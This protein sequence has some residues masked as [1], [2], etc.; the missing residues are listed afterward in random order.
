[1]KKALLI[2]SLISGLFLIGTLTAHAEPP[3]P[4]FKPAEGPL[5][6]VNI[7]QK[8]GAR[9]PLESAFK[10]ENAQDV[11][12]G[13]YYQDRPVIQALVYYECPMLCTLVVNGLVKTLKT[14]KLT[15]GKDFEVVIVS[16]DPDETPELARPKKE[17]YL[18]EYGRPETADGWH[19]L[20]GS[21]ESIAE[22][23]EA[24][25]FSYAYDAKSG[26]FAHASAIMVVTPEGKIARYLFGIDYPA[27]E[28]RLALIH[29]SDGKIGNLIDQV[30]LYCFHYDPVSGQYSLAI[31]NLVRLGGLVIM[32]VIGGFI[33]LT[34][35]KKKV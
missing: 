11:L 29:A 4:V 6:K 35:R 19:F 13:D 18:K 1:M 28:L 31:M 22:L 25:G 3:T 2:R 14:L 32:I 26:E 30:L 33:F 12:L 23:T 17:I 9:L 8:L 5:E 10:D 16:F 21:A 15:P 34:N 7:E 27:T 24:S 20:T